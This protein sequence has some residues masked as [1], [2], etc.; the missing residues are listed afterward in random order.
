MS[1]E[2]ADRGPLRAR[3]VFGALHEGG[4]EFVLIGGWA[5]NAHGYERPTRDVDI[6]PNP[7]REN[8]KRLAA[9]LAELDARVAGMEEFADPKLPEPDADGLALGGNFVLTTRLGGVD[10]MQLVS[11][12]LTYD[13]LA[14]DA[15]EAE[16]FGVPI[17]FCSYEKLV[18]M[19]TAAG[20]E[21][22]RIDLANLKSIRGEI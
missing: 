2:E 7:D 5:V 10:I 19:K 8:L 12:D 21:S 3:E 11:P 22:D 4:V 9:V 14:L 16:V 13:D 20:R 1:G 17:R 18:A 15:L 6:T